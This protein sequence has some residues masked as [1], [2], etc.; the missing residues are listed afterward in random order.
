VITQNVDGL[1]QAA[2]TKNVVELHGGLDRTIC[3]NCGALASRFETQAMLRHVNPHFTARIRAVNPDGDAD[4]SDA[5]VDCF[6]M[7]DCRRCA[8]GPLKPD[9]VFFGEAVPRQRVERCYALVEASVGLLVLGSSLTVMSGYRFV[10][11]AAAL[12]I[13]IAIVNQGPTRADDQADIRIS[14][15]LG[16]VLTELVELTCPRFAVP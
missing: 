9:V 4:V 3:L 2:G 16:A 11:R 15:P 8:S 6:T 1:H 14:A 5:D 12:C 13:P 7:V 10:R